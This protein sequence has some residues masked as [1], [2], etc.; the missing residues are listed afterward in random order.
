MKKI[1]YRMLQARGACEDQVDLFRKTFPNGVVPSLAA[2]RKAARAGLD[3]TW[4]ANKFLSAPALAAYEKAVAPEWSEYAKAVVAALAEYEKARAAAWSE[5][6][7]ATAA[8]LAAYDKAVAPARSAYEKARAAA[9]AAYDKAVAPARAAY[10]KARAA[11]W[12]EY[13]KAVA[14]ARSAYEKATA[15]ALWSV[16]KKHGI[17]GRK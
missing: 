6:E 10:E 4:F 5:H 12:A 2:C 17:G 16:I 15:P 3:L 13:E 9:L 14:P 1:T 11:A 7:K 8:A